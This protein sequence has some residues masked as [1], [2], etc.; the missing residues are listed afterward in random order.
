MLHLHHRKPSRKFV[1][2]RNLG[3]ERAEELVISRVAPVRWHVCRKKKSRGC[4]GRGG[5]ACEV[6][7]VDGDGAMDMVEAELVINTR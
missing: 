1:S 3:E 2:P 7:L 5:G 6:L 4:G